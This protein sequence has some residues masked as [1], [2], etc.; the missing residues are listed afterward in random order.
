MSRQRYVLDFEAVLRCAIAENAS[1][2]HFKVGLPP[3]IRV[4][5]RLVDTAFDRTTNKDLE[6]LKGALLP[7]HRVEEFAS[8]NETDFGFTVEGIGRFRGNMFRQQG[9]VGLALRRIMT[10]VPSV[11]ALNLPPVVAR[12]A[13]EPR[14][15][16]LVTG[17]SGAGKSMTLAS[18]IGIIN[19]TQSV[20]V[21]TIED[22]IEIVHPDGMASINQREIGLDTSDYAQAMRRV[23]RQDPDVILI[24]E[25]RDAETVA[26]ALSAAETGHVVFSTL[27]TT[28]ATE[29][30]NR[31]VDFFP[32]HEQ[33]QVRRTLAGC[34]RGVISQRLVPR[35]DRAGRVPATEVMVMTGAIAE[36]IIDPEGR[37]SETIEE[38]IAKG[39]WH[40]MQT[41]DQSLFHLFQQGL[42]SLPDAMTAASNPHDFRL[43]L[44]QAGLVPAA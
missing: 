21:I 23:V 43:S 14:G 29:S 2:V 11:E 30:I 3:R 7:P 20:N 35:P 24:G 25:M 36:Q 6:A 32:P 12:L 42:V 5:G 8:T 38:L 19:A 41:F 22:P 26:A 44:Q 15:L 27:H 4:H 39:E 33:Q 16:V 1:D 18:M 13:A 28:N 37:K 9:R 40:G 31:I 17:P 34:L 10:A